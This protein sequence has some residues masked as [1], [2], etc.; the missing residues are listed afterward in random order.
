MASCLPMSAMTAASWLMLPLW[1]C[2]ASHRSRITEV[3]LAL[4][5]KKLMCLWR[6]EHKNSSRWFVVLVFFFGG[7]GFPL[8]NPHVS[9]PPVCYPGKLP[10]PCF[11]ALPPPVTLS[12]SRFMAV[13]QH[14]R[15]TVLQHL[16]KKKIKAIRTQSRSTNPQSGFFFYLELNSVSSLFD[17]EIASKSLYSK[18]YMDFHCEVGSDLFCFSRGTFYN[19][20]QSMTTKQRLA[21]R[22]AVCLKLSGSGSPR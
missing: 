15:Y 13:P 7:G 20:T 22:P 1:K 18:S 17:V 16:T 12:L 5:A 14:S 11:T 3:G 19:Q 4:D 9:L 6:E 10:A 8:L 21:G 2:C